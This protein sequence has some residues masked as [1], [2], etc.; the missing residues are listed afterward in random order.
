M[1]V[2]GASGAGPRSSAPLIAAVYTAAILLSALLIFWIEPLF[3]KMILPVV[4][5]TPATWITALM[6]YQTALLLGYGY[7]FLLTRALPLPAQVAVHM[8]ALA[9]AA[10]ALP[11]TLPA[12]AELADRPVFQVLFMLT[13]G[14]GALLL[15]LSATAPLLQHW[16]TETAHPHAH[17]P[18]FLYAASNVGSLGALLAFPLLVE[19]R[20]GLALQ[21]HA[22]AIGYGALAALILAC[23]ALV[24]R[25]SLGESAHKGRQPPRVRPAHPRRERAIWVAP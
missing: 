2:A 7:S 18:Y 8:A 21:T 22:W 13:A 12:A 15:A 20:L 6:F 1:T 5:G 24:S 10:F 23:A 4:G 16:F 25:R 17:D 11:P 19:P 3:P 14:I 9:L